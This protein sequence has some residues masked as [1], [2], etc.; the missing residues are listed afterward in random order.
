MVCNSIATTSVELKVELTSSV[1]SRLLEAVTGEKVTAGG[2]EWV[3][4]NS[5]R[6][7]F[8]SNIVDMETTWRAYVS[9]EEFEAVEKKLR[10][11]VVK[12][13]QAVIL[14]RLQAAGKVESVR[15]VKGG[16]TLKIKV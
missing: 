6:I 14:Q 13:Q 10:S 8:T 11:M 3:E 2:E 5:Y 16:L 9:P 15:E 7:Y 12:A 1:A 4:T